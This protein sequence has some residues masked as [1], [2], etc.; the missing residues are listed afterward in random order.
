MTVILLD[1]GKFASV[2]GQLAQVIRVATAGSSQKTMKLSM[3]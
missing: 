3:T 2:R 1:A